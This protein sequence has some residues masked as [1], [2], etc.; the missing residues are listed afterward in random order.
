MK[1]LFDHANQ[2]LL[3]HG[4]FQIQIEQTKLAL[5][6]TG[7]EV[8]FLRWWDDSQRGDIIHFFGRPFRS[9][10]DFAQQKGIKIVLTDLLTAQGSRSPT[11]LATQ[12]V[13]MRTSEVLLPKTFR[14]RLGWDS[15][16]PADACVALTNWEAHL[17]QLLFKV[18]AEKMH[19]V[20]NGVEDV[21][22]SSGPQQRGK[23]LVCT[24]TIAD[25]KRVLEL[26]R[27]AVEAKTPVWIIGRPYNERDAYAREFL[28][29]SAAHADY[30]RY[31]GAIADRAALARIYREA[32]GFV[33]LSTMESLSLSALEA[34]AC[35]CP[36]LLS[37]LPWATS[38][39]GNAARYCPATA[40][41]TATAKSLREFYD[42]A[43]RMNTKIQV[44][45]WPDVAR[46]LKGIYE[47]VLR[48]SR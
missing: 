15:Y 26:A 22:F 17:M 20:P 33:L 28:T 29:F 3:A 43:P 38:V 5:E 25:R 2:F 16:A 45:T 39:F 46:Q 4:G 9:Y 7:V 13:V 31:E 27:A 41:T 14:M 18:S 19:V 37:D 47:G 12:R 44:S 6:K 30:V 21:F 8:E 34:A 32:R 1:V 35:N 36:L 24:A 10:V 23:W 40:S 48:T 11:R 42:A